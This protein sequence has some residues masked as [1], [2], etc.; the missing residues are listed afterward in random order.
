MFYVTCFTECVACTKT[1]AKVS[2]MVSVRWQD[3]WTM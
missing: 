1:R 3:V 2:G